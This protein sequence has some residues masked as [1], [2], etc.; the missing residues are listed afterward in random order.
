MIVTDLLSFVPD[1]TH[2]SHTHLGWRNTETFRPYLQ[3]DSFFSHAVQLLN[4]LGPDWN[5]HEHKPAFC[6]RTFS[7]LLLLLQHEMFTA[8][9]SNGQF[10]CINSI[11]LCVPVGATFV[12][13]VYWTVSC[14][15]QFAHLAY[16]VYLCCY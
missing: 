11:Q 7:S 4:T 5:I 12:T 6:R 3:T 13:H 9:T 8:F 15:L 2:P 16:F 10:I 1:R 14:L